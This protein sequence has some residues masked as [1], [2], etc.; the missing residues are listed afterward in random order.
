MTSDKESQ[1]LCKRFEELARSAEY[2][3]QNTFSTFLS[4]NEISL[5]Y[6]YTANQIGVSYS[7]FG[8]TQDAERKMICFHGEDYQL[9]EGVISRNRNECVL[10]YDKYQAIYPI[11]CIHIQPLNQKFADHLSHRDFLGAIMN[12]GIERSTI[13]DIL[14][15]DNEGYVFCQ[16]GISDYIIGSLDKIRHTN[17]TCDRISMEDFKIQPNFIEISGTV[18]SVRLDSVI[19]TAFKTSRSQVI[20]YIEGGKVFVNGRET[21]SNSYSLKDNDIVSV[22]GMGK[23]IYTGMNH[24]TKK[25][26]YSITIKR[27]N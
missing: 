5:F 9:D 23:F 17:V 2:K 7:L 4:M 19:A 13:G 21:L 3:Y 27:Y 8:G 25:G 24:Q 26:R 11:E 6:Q 20:G 10:C 15:K 16:E 12:L 22:R 18:S 1:I 14:L